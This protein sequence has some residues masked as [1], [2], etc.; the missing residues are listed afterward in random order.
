MSIKYIV[1]S[2]TAMEGIDIDFIELFLPCK[3]NTAFGSLNVKLKPSTLCQ[4]F[5][6]GKIIVIGGETENETKEVF[7]SYMEA[8]ADLGHP[9][10]YKDYHIQNIVACYKHPQR[11]RL[12]HLAEKN[13]LEFEPELFPAVRYRDEKRKV[14]VN[15]FHTGNC[16]ILGAK[17]VRIVNEIVE[18]LKNLLCLK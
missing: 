17:S 11:A 13:R 7:D 16:V 8:F 1:V 9:I 5:P 3:R 2:A 14:T 18:V 10:E 4:Q 15:I 12:D 6:N